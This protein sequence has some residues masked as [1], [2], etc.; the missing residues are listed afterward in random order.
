MAGAPKG[1]STS[2]GQ[3]ER[4]SRTSQLS[5]IEPAKLVNV[6]SRAARGDVREYADLCD[7]LI[8]FDGHIRANYETRLAMVGGAPWEITPGKSRDPERQAAAEDGAAFAGEVLRGWDAFEP[9][10][11]ELLDATGIGWALQEVV[12]D[13]VDGAEVPIGNEWIHPRRTTFGDAWELR[14]VDDG[15]TFDHVGSAIDD[16]PEGK[17][18]QHFPRLR[19]SY[20]GVAGVLRSCMWIYLFRRW[21]MQF[22]VR[23]VEKFAWPTMMGQMKRGAGSEA[24]GEMATFLRDAAS[25]HYIVTEAEQEV[26]YL[27]TLV[28]DAGSFAALDEALKGE[29]SKAILGSTDQTEPVKVGAW[30]A[31]ESRKGT[32]VDSRASVDARQLERTHR[33]QL[34]RWMMEFNAPLFGG[35]VPAI[36]EITFLVSGTKSPIPVS[37][38]GAAIELARSSGLQPTEESIREL[39]NGVGLKLEAIPPGVSAPKSLDLAPTDLANVVRGGEARASQGLPPFG[40][41]RDDKTVAQLGE[42]APAEEDEPEGPP[43]PAPNRRPSARRIRK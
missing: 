3:Q 15:E 20:P 41:E 22:W 33:A 7:R 23:G 8:W 34:L 17:F 24:R 2:V 30:K 11:M 35:V 32:T 28:K 42:T 43:S 37:E 26:K 13:N 9:L 21:A 40:D 31:V 16:F 29:A 5:S 18:I 38:L 6:L 10:N 1:R 4:N 27:E 36:P 39:V 19:G 14:L 25:D 12:W